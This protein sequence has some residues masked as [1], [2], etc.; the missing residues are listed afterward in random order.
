MA[1]TDQPGAEA[2]QTFCRT[3][4]KVPEGSWY[5]PALDWIGIS[6]PW[7]GRGDVAS[8]YGGGA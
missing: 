3:S 4:D 8:H 1:P 2:Q 5:G 7:A 6:A